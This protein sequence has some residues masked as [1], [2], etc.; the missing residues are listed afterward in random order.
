M[1]ILKI[2][3]ISKKFGTAEIL[4]NVSFSVDEDEIFFILGPSGCGKTTL[5]RIITGF[6]APDSG[7]IM[8]SGRDITDMPPANRNIG[9]VFQNY[10]LW[11]HMNVWQNVSYGL[12]I[13]KF[14]PEVIR[15][16]T[17]KVL[18]TT[19]LASFADHFPPKLSGGQQQRVAL[20]RAIVTEPKLLLLDEP[21]SNL[22][23]RLREEMREEIRRIQREIKIAMIYVTHDQK[24]AMAMGQKIAVMNEGKLVQT[25]TPVQ[26]YSSPADKFT[27]SFLGD[28]NIMEGEIKSISGKYMSVMTDEGLFTI[29]RKAGDESG[30][31]VEIGFRPENIFYGHDINIITGTIADVEYLGETVKVNIKTEKNRIFRLRMFSGEFKKIKPEGKISFSVSP[32]DFIIFK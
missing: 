1:D 16:K 17:E 31:R 18:Q 14:P 23:A 26:L 25:G 15:R 5:L 11:P 28:I 13:K 9:M 2:S 7:K 21:L 24:E 30:G 27:A 8:L 10:A 12:E 29:D 6:T 19:K 20:A 4:R 32:E 3:G 22:D